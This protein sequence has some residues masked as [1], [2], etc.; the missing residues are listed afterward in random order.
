MAGL[1]G[2]GKTTATAKLALYLRKQERSCLMVGT[3][4]YRPAAIDQL[5]TLGKQI[6]VPVF[7]MGTDADPVE[8]A[9][10]GIEK[11]KELGVDTVIVDTAGRLQ[12]DSD[13]MGELARI[14]DTIK[15]DDTL[16]VVD[17]MTG[18]EA[19]NLT[20]TFHD[21]IGITGA[22]LTKLDGDSRGG[23]ALSVRQVSGQPIKF[24]GVGEKVEALE[25][26]YPDRLASRILNMGDI[27]TLVEKAQEEI[28]L[29]DVEKMQSKIME[30]KF[31]FN[32]FIKQM[33]LLKNMGSLGG[34]LKL[35]PGMGK[36]SGADLAK[37]ETQLKRTESMISSM[38]KAEKADP[39]LLAQSPSR[40]RRV[41]KGSGFNE[42]DVSKLVQDFTKM[43]S[44]MQNMGRGMPGMGMP[45]M[46]MPGMGGGMPG[47][48]MP[49]MGGYPE[50][51]RRKKPKKKKKGF[52]SL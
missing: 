48:G 52:G 21:Q 5:L 12:I 50:Q 15:P 46:G 24:V 47:M 42:K 31:D 9:R 2:T 3:D 1:Q 30:A 37:G 41:A 38:T 25:P 51:G 10:Q 20:Y 33:R 35:I 28:D 34:V 44:M 7:E 11:G 29:A 8:I 17:A 45:G 27:L 43:R 16:L 13:M 19:A 36:I 40:R 23:A 22:I 4:V 14:K 32:D 6:D 18:Q 39:D 49:G 26:F